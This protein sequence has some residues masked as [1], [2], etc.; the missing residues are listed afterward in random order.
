M[1]EIHSDRVFNVLETALAT[2]HDEARERLDEGLRRAEASGFDRLCAFGLLEKGKLLLATGRADAARPLLWRAEKQAT[3][4]EANDLVFLSWFYL[5]KAA[6]AL[7][8]DGREAWRRCLSLRSLQ[9]GRL[10]EL[11]ELEHLEAAR[12]F[13]T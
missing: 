3:A 2:R 5:L 10:P 7:G 6:L 9:E 8:E 11:D 4:V 12:E 13:G 1:P